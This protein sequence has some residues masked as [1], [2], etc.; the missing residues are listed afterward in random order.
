MSERCEWNP[1]EC[2]AAYEDDGCR[3]EATLCVGANGAWHLCDECSMHPMFARL[4]KTPRTQLASV[5]HVG[6]QP[7]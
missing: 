4:K 2:R 1:D 7:T 6:R 5:G 3:N